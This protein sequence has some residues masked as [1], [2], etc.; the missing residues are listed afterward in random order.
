MRQTHTRTHTTTRRQPRVA[1][2]RTN[3]SAIISRILVKPSQAKPRHA[4]AMKAHVVAEQGGH[5]PMSM[6][7]THTLQYNTLVHY[8]ST[9]LNLAC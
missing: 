7:T 4:E 3:S 5:G 2:G 1:A 6:M 8:Y 9:R